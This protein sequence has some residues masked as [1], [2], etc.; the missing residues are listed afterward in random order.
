MRAVENSVIVGRTDSIAD[1][2]LG[3]AHRH[4]K[5][6]YRFSVHVTFSPLRNFLATIARAFRSVLSFLDGVLTALVGGA[7]VAERGVLAGDER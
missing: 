5:V 7:Q 4:F 1:F 3:Y 2:A 6:W